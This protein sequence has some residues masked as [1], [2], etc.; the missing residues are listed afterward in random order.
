MRRLDDGFIETMPSFFSVL[1]SAI[2]VPIYASSL[3]DVVIYTEKDVPYVEV[4]LNPSEDAKKYKVC[5]VANDYRQIFL[6]QHG[7]NNLDASSD[8]TLNIRKFIEGRCALV[9]ATETGLY[10]K[11]DSLKKPKALVQRLLAVEQLDSAMYAAF[12]KHTDPQILQAFKAAA[13]KVSNSK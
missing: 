6:R 2:S 9:L 10:D 3:A 5:V 12:N 8:S 4:V 7:F 13:Q 1:I 11:L